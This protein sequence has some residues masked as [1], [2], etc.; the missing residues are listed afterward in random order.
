MSKSSPWN[1]N[2]WFSNDPDPW[3]TGG[4]VNNKITKQAAATKE[5]DDFLQL[6]RNKPFWRWGE[7]GHDTTRI[8]PNCNAEYDETVSQC[9]CTLLGYFKDYRNEDFPIYVGTVWKDENLL[10]PNHCCWNHIVGLPQKRRKNFDTNDIWWETCPIFNWQKDYFFDPFESADDL[11]YIKAGG[12]AATETK[13]RHIAW[14]V[15]EGYKY[16][17]SDI[18]VIVGPKLDLALKIIGRYKELFP[19][20]I[21]TARNMAVVNDCTLGTFASDHIESIRSLKQPI[22]IIIDEFDFFRTGELP[23][24]LHTIFRYIGKAGAVVRAI[25]TPNEPG[26]FCETLENDAVLDDKGK[27]RTGKFL[28]LKMH[29]SI[30]LGTIYTIREIEEAK[31]AEGF[32]REYGLQYLGGAGNFFDRFLVDACVCRHDLYDPDVPFREALTVMA[33]DTGWSVNGNRNYFAIVIGSWV[34]FKVYVMYARKWKNPDVQE[35]LKISK[36]LRMKYFVDKTV[37]D[38]SDPEYIYMLK[39]ELREF[40]WD[41]HQV[42]KENYKFMMVEP[43]PFTKEQYNFLEHDKKMIE[44]KA[45]VIHPSQQDVVIAF[46]SAYVEDRKFIKEKSANNDVLDAT[47]MMLRKFY[48][49]R[50]STYGKT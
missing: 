47:S 18:P 46:K 2:D 13:L 4:S 25:S 8:C 40:P 38:G 26:G 49:R 7:K 20:Y 24:V 34:N 45:I 16:C 48:D 6:C 30:A 12:I 23:N 10:K 50:V 15:S 29:Y 41:Y 33:Q 22:E 37:I 43:L 19:F 3:Q 5:I 21:D 17:A 27:L 14:R 32:D 28:L 39:K 1:L 9:K 35:M 11:L 36:D 44:D 42:D 31:K